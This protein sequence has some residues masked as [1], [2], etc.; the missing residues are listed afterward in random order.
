MA[1]LCVIVGIFEIIA[2]IIWMVNFHDNFAFIGIGIGEVVSAFI[3]FY[4]A[5]IGT[6]FVDKDEQDKKYN[7]L[8]DELDQTRYKLSLVI[9]YSGIP[10]MEQKINQRLNY[11]KSL[12]SL[13][14]MEKGFPIVLLKEK[15]ASGVKIPIGTKG[16]LEEKFSSVF[17]CKFYVD[18][19]EYIKDCTEEEIENYYK[20]VF[21]L[22]AE[23]ANA[24]YY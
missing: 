11:E 19:K 22:E 13:Y 10:D 23:N 12:V 4:I 15:T 24:K 9:Q 21:G 17:R 16:Y 5:Y 14:N 6:S 18:G 2:G 3:M 20:Y 8:K 1:F 7:L